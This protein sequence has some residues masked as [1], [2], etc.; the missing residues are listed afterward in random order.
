MT[1]LTIK[2]KA[3]KRI[4]SGH[5][6]IFS[7][8]LT[9]IPK[10]E[11]GTIVRIKGES[12]ANYCTAFYNPHSLIAARLLLTD[13]EAD[14]SFFVERIRAALNFRES[15][16]QGEKTYRLIFGESDLL[17][18][19]VIDRYENCFSMQ[20][21]SAGADKLKD[22]IIEALLEVVPE[23]QGI[24]EK[25]ISHLRALEGLDNVEQIVYG[26]IPESILT[27]ESGIKLNIS[28]E[29]SQ[30]TGYYLDQRLNRL[31]LR[32]YCKD[33]KVLDCFANQGGFA[34]NAAAAGA[35]LAVGVDSSESA[36]H[37]AKIN[38]KL[39]N[40]DNCDFVCSEVF[41]FLNAEIEKGAKWDV[42]VLDPPAFA[43]NKKSVPQALSAYGKLNRLALRLLSRGGILVSSSCSQNVSRNDFAETLHKEIAKAEHRAALMFTGAQSPDHPILTAM[44][45]TDYLKFFIYRII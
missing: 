22:V 33:K 4:A 12:G 28:L 24:I 9:E 10:I 20:L 16:F 30:K 1:E 23:T 15:I 25:N 34:L 35:K 5:L 7:N 14:K 43:K 32:Q 11:A 8:E 38:A 45:E 6:W 2:R 13:K 21:L 27:T 44:P 36:C 31:Q 41:D 29:N 19:I 18:G 39:N 37:K 3:E 42:I 40:F 26:T 17:P